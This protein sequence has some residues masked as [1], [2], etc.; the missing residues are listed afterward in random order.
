MIGLTNDARRRLN[1]IEEFSDLGS[2][3]NVAMRDLDIR[4]AGNLLGGEQSGFI[5]EI[6][7]EM[8]N[9]ILDEA[10]QELK[11]DEFT[12]LFKHELVHKI[13]AKDCTIETDFEALIPDAYVRNI[14]ERL[15]LYNELSS[16]TT[17]EQLHAFAEKLRDRF[18]PVPQQVWDLLDVIRLR[19]TAKQLGFEKLIL[20]NGSL[21]AHFPDEKKQAY[22][23]SQTFTSILAFVQSNSSRCKMKQST[24]G[25][26]L[27]VMH[28]P[29]IQHAKAVFN[30]MRAFVLA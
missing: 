2:G 15:T 27:Q 17:E 28:V 14:G 20:K 6:G 7:F 22:Y 25:L 11:E 24:K 16:I 19:E 13:E 26:Q 3:F 4:G 29:E 12:E 18:G 5:A 21:G 23:Q 1:A 10:I 30:E 9:K 8:Y